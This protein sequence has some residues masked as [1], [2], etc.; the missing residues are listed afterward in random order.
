[1]Q[2]VLKHLRI[3]EKAEKISNKNDWYMV[4]IE[5]CEPVERNEKQVAKGYNLGKSS[6][7]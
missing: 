2:Y 7:N 4:S 5:K 3:M 6:F 1:M